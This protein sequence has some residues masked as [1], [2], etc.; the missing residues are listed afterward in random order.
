MISV[1]LSDSV[2]KHASDRDTADIDRLDTGRVLYIQ[3]YDMS[4]AHTTCR[5]E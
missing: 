4:Y 2:L 1:W 5:I 3:Q